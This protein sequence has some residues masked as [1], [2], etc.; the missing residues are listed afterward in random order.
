[1]DND[2]YKNYVNDFIILL[3]DK[4]SELKNDFF[5]CKPEDKDYI[6]GQIMSYYDTLTIL[7]SQAEVFDIYLYEFEDLNLGRFLTL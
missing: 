1:M 5:T 4:L 3:I 2:C 7:K 6:R